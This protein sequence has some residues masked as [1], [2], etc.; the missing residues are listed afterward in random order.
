[1]ATQLNA[2]QYD[3]LRAAQL[4]YQVCYHLNGRDL[5]AGRYSSYAYAEDAMRRMQTISARHDSSIY[6]WI[7]ERA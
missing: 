6:Y 5:R 3:I 7:E 4:P 1:M 2:N